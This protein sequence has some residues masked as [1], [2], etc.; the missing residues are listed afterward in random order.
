MIV[1]MYVCMIL[2]NLLCVLATLWLIICLST[3]APGRK[4]SIMI[5]CN[6]IHQSKIVN[7]PCLS[8]GELSYARVSTFLHIPTFHYSIRPILQTSNPPN[9]HWSISIARHPTSD[10]RLPTSVY[11][12]LLSVSP[13]PLPSVSTA[14]ANLSPFSILPLSHTYLIP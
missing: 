7:S 1:W 13:S 14:S 3:K 6:F 12:L 10:I 2:K 5:C 11:S 4:E 9:F 8:S